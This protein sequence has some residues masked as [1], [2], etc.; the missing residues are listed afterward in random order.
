MLT[1]V[2]IKHSTSSPADTAGLMADY[3]AFDRQRAVRRQYTKAFG[4]MAV[5]VVLGALFGRVPRDEASV[6]TGLLLA[7]PVVLAFLEAIQWF[8]LVRRLDRVRA[9]LQSVKKS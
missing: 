5:I 3:L 9:R 7:P 8:R 2:Q 1:L 6:V 4:G